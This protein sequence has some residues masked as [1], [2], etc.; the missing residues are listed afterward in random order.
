MRLKRRGNMQYI[1]PIIKWLLPY[2][3]KI[4]DKYLPKLLEDIINKI[5]NNKKKDDVKMS[6]E[7]TTTA[8]TVTSEVATTVAPVIINA[9]EEKKDELLAKLKAEITTTSSSY[10][11]F[12]NTMYIALLN[13]ADDYL[14]EKLMD[15][16]AKL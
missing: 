5:K 14:V 8:T 15:K 16:L 2:F 9:V 10:V 3:L 1:T 4:A 7:N 11:K 13:G 6:E 12:R